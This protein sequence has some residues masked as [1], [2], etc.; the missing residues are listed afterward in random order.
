MSHTQW[1]KFSALVSSFLSAN[2]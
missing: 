2:L 1:T